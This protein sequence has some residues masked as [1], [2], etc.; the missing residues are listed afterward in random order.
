MTEEEARKSGRQIKIGKFPYSSNGHAMAI[1][2][3]DGFVKIVGD[4]ENGEILG[5]HI[6]GAHAT[7]LISESVVAKTMEAAVE[8]LAEAIHAHPTLS[9]AVMEAAM[10]WNKR[11]VHTPKNS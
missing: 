5:V 8:D 6:L 4:A 11:A 7:E 1:G 10:G 9:E 2:E 3:T